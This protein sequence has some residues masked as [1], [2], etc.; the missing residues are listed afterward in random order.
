[1]R[2]RKVNDRTYYNFLF[3]T[4]KIMQPDENDL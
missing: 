1:M 4:A 2:V 3:C